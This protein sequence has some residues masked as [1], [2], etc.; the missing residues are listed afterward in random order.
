MWTRDKDEEVEW[1]RLNHEP[2]HGIS[3]RAYFN[4]S[5]NLYPSAAE[6]RNILFYCALELRCAIERVLF[7]YLSHIRSGSLAKNESKL[8]SAETLKA[9][10]FTIEPEFSKKIEFLNLVLK[11]RDIK[12]QFSVPDLEKISRDYGLLNNYLHAQKRRA[13]MIDAKWWLAFRRLIESIHDYAWP[14]C[15]EVRINIQLNVGALPLFQEFSRGQ[16]TRDEVVASLK[17]WPDDIS[18]NTNYR[19]YIE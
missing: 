5:Y 4:R 12:T 7:E 10:I 16:K 17:P 19:N 1:K 8:W 13:H 15:A 6:N 9:A 18:I 11:A 3:A 2:Y 14:Y